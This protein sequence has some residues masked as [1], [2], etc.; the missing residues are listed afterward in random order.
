ML[1]PFGFFTGRARRV[2]LAFCSVFAL[3]ACG[4]GGG[5]DG[6]TGGADDGGSQARAGVFASGRIEGYGSVIVNGVHFDHAAAT[7]RDDDGN[8]VNSAYLKLGMTVDVAGGPLSTDADGRV[9]ST[10]SELR[11]GSEIRGPVTAVG[12]NSLTVLGQTVSLSSITVFDGFTGGRLGIQVGDLVEVYGFLDA[13]TGAIAATRVEPEDHLNSYR[14]RGAVAN[15]DPGTQTFTLGG[16][17]VSY[18]NVPVGSRPELANGRLVRVVLQ[19]TQ[20][21]GVWLAT[22]VRSAERDTGDVTAAEVEGVVSGFQSLSSFRL[23]GFNVNAAGG[24]VTFEGGNS[25]QLVNGARVEVEGEISGGVLV[26][27][28]VAFEDDGSD[29]ARFE[30]TGQI[31]AVNVLAQT[32]VVQGVTVSFA[33]AGLDAAQLL[34]L[35]V[36][37]RVEVEGGLGANGTVVQA[38][39]IEFDD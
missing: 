16:A 14:L 39:R 21:A 13:G 9:R 25:A 31:Q 17:T 38:S 28:K 6:D 35:V 27:R 29:A 32:F 37:A 30:L 20:Q 34:K 2:A 24:G 3:A 15:L 11:F 19:T 23:N 10:A 33:D 1:Q 8:S 5:D 36:G 7:I 22:E 18:A 4:G 26:V 12:V